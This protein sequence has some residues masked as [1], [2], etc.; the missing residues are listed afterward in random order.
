MNNHISNIMKAEEENKYSEDYVENYCTEDN[1]QFN[2]VNTNTIA[3]NYSD[4][5][6]EPEVIF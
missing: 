2:I 1:L 5:I 6:P 4:N 3:E